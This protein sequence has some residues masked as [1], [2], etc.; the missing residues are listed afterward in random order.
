MFEFHQLFETTNMKWLFSER[1]SSP[2]TWGPTE[3]T[4]AHFVPFENWFSAAFGL[5]VVLGLKK[6]QQYNADAK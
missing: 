5:V 4:K 2:I 3:P 6:A 1:P